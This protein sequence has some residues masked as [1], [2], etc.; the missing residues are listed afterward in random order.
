MS[1]LMME[2]HGSRKQPHT[3][4][5]AANGRLLQSI[6][7]HAEHCAN[8][9]QACTAL[10]S[11]CKQELETMSS[12]CLTGAAAACLAAVPCLPFAALES[13]PFPLWLLPLGL[14]FL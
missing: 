9:F 7:K 12:A 2:R 14:P 5:F 4:M 1:H 8:M 3:C 10:L 6:S 11:V 13:L